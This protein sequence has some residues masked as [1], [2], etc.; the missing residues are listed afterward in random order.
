MGVEMSIQWHMRVRWY[1]I[2]LREGEKPSLDTIYGLNANY[3]GPWSERGYADKYATKMTLRHELHKLSGPRKA[4]APK[5]W[6]VASY[7]PKTNSWDT[8]PAPAPNAAELAE[9]Q[10]EKNRILTAKAQEA[11]RKTT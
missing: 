1:A 4:G 6:M 5:H 11:E 2:T 3:N 9:H 7:D 10:V 8:Y